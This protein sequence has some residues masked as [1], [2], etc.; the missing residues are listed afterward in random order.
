MTLNL[1]NQP[2]RDCSKSKSLYNKRLEPTRGNAG[3]FSDKTRQ[4]IGERDK[5]LCVKCGSNQIESVP[6]HVIF[7]SALGKGTV[8]NGVTVCRTCHDW[9]HKCRAGRVWFEEYR[10]NNLLQT[11]R[12]PS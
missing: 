7:K 8:D 6:H 11:L 9:A 2:V 3:K 10:I 1:S 5:W 4:I 12:I